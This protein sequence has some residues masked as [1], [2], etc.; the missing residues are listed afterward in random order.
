MMPSTYNF[1][2]LQ[3]SLCIILKEKKKKKGKMYVLVQCVAVHL[4]LLRFYI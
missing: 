3:Q 1:A 4:S 2:I